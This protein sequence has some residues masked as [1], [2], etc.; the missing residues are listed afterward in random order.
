MTIQEFSNAFDTLL[1]SYDTQSQFGEQASKREIVLDEYEKSFYLTKAQEEVVVNFYNGKNPYG[2]SFESTE[3]MRRYLESLVKTK[4]YS[5]EEQI[6]GTGVS[7]SSVFYQLPEDVAF[8]TMEQV[9]YEDEALGCYS[10]STAT[11]YPV[12]QDEYSR[13]KNNPFRGP[14]RYK[15]IR[16]DTGNNTVELVS[17]YKIGEYMLKYLSR[18]EPI[19][20]EDLPN[21]LTIEGRGEH[22]ECKLNSILHD[23]ILERAVQ[24]ALQAK[25]I[26]VNK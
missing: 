15:A 1:N 3:E 14:T 9:T 26:S 22:S 4:V 5:T 12:T 18:P 17:K 24:M 23:T 2:D 21:D 8:I 10:G 7:I 19:I 6:D 16:L 20:L 13:I 11:V 25:G